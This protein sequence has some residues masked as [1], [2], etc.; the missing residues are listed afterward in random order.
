MWKWVPVKFGSYV[1]SKAML[2][3]I[4]SR[5]I[6]CG[7]K[8][9]PG[10]YTRIKEYIP[11]IYRYVKRSGRCRKPKQKF[12]NNSAKVQLNKNTYISRKKRIKKRTNR[13][14]KW[15]LKFMRK[16]YH[17]RYKTTIPHVQTKTTSAKHAFK[18][19]P[20]S[21]GSSTNNP[22]NNAIFRNRY[23]YDAQFSGRR[24]LILENTKQFK[25]D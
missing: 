11:W 7:R 22:Y 14:K 16:L 3:G 15:L 24:H 10:V 18:P 21:S 12:K 9:T 1:R 2:I 19:A 5:G 4:V 8:D 17:Y 23:N 13:K 20:K 25:F 6:G